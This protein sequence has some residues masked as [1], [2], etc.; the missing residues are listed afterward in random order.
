MHARI[1]QPLSLFNPFVFLPFLSHPQFSRAV[2][3]LGLEMT[4]FP[5]FATMGS[6]FIGDLETPELSMY[7]SEPTMISKGA[8]SS[9][10]AAVAVA[11]TQIADVHREVRILRAV[12]AIRAFL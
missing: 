10:L 5:T 6:D 7:T 8:H 12:H 11:D 2:T 3:Q 1:F 4:H 9:N